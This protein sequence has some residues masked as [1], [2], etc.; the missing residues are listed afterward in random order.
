[1]QHYTNTLFDTFGN[2][3]S[4]AKDNVYAAGTTTPSTIYS[5]NIG[6]TTPNPITTGADGSYNFYAANGTYDLLFTHPGYSFS[7]ADTKGIVLFDATVGAFVPSVGG[8]ATYTTRVGTSY[9]LGRLVFID[10]LVTINVLGT[11]STSVISGAPF[12]A[13]EDTAL[14]VGFTTGLAVSPVSIDPFISSG[15]TDIYLYGRTAGA[16]ASTSLAMLGN[17][18]IIRISGCYMAT[19]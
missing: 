7:A 10:L 15:T 6:T 18:A 3:I 14:S 12:V 8:T 17:A 16:T 13:S 2:A 1:M 19:T 11:G 9:K 4:G 5:D